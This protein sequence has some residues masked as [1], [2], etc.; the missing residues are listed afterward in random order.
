MIRK[1]YENLKNILKEMGSVVVASS[2]GA[3]S[4]L[5]LAAAADVLGEKVLAVTAESPIRFPEEIARARKMASDLKVEHIVIRSDELEDEQVLNNSPERCYFCKRRIFSKLLEVARE[6]GMAFVADGSNLDDSGAFRPG[7][8]AVEELGVRSPLEEAGLTKEEIRAISKKLGLRTWNAASQSCLLTRFPYNSKIEL[9]GL[10][11]VLAA[12]AF[13]RGLGFDEVRARVH[14]DRVRIEV[15]P[16][17]VPLLENAGTISCV[18]EELER[19]GYGHVEV[20]PE[21]Y[22]TGSMDRN[23]AWT[24]NG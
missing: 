3:D 4:T 20:D 16:E 6:R 9:A 24:K 18:S 19:L 15:S 7:R 17:E 21:G 14:E 23:M 5:L 1:K 11:K 2:G 12:E 8:R 13:I 22:R 10:E